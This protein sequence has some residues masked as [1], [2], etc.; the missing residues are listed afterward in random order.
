MIMKYLLGWFFLL[1]PA[2]INGAMRE[3]LYKP[4]VGDLAAHQVSTATGIVLFGLIIWG[5]S[6]LWPIPTLQQAW[7]IGFIWLG[8][9]VC[10]EFLFGNYVL[11][12][13]LTNLL[14]DYDS[15]R[16]GCGFWF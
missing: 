9:T 8:M 11:G 2:V 7:T 1:I 12:H 5:M 13:P 4:S 3:F 6:R 16:E 15:W 10:F 14:H